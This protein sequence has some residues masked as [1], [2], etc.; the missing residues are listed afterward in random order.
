MAS[1]T[2]RDIAR[3]KCRAARGWLGWSQQELARQAHVG[4]ST[5]KDFERGE[6]TPIANNLSAMRRAIQ[7]AGIQLCFDEN[8]SAIG[9]RSEYPNETP[10]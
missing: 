8:G 2:E 3:H 1:A 10:N 9:I 7:T 6:R 5:V 4:L